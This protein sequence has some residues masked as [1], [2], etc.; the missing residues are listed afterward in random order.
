MATSSFSLP[1][2]QKERLVYALVASAAAGGCPSVNLSGLNTVADTA[3]NVY[4]NP[5]AELGVNE[6]IAGLRAISIYPNPA[7]D[8]LVIEGAQQGATVVVTNV[9]GAT[10]ASASHDGAGSFKVYV[11]ELPLGVYVVRC[12]DSDRMASFRIVKQ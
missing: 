9:L 6:H 4:H 2:G 8:V 7:H 5:P 1:A 3:W 10:V 12:V 11:K